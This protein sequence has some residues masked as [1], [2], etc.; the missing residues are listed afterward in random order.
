MGS[1]KIE[2]ILLDVPYYSQ[3]LDV[4]DVYWQWRA[5][6]M[7]CLKMAMDYY[8][9]G[10]ESLANLIKEGADA[11]GYCEAGWIHESLLSL[12][13]ERGLKASRKEYKSQ[14]PKEQEKLIKSAIR[15]KIK[16]LKNKQPVIVSA[17]RKFQEEKNF[18]MVI[19]TAFEKRGKKLLGFYYHD[20]D[21]FE[22]SEGMHK[23]VP[24]ETFKKYWRK[25]S[26]YVKI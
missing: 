2:K 20:P 24:I 23:F 12:A 5:C 8:K 22:R 13:R 16:S 21:A 14:D 10:A 7:A 19:L 11:G 1:T 6:G 15:E 9:K 4:K 18:H 3:H 17:I 26:I 25:M